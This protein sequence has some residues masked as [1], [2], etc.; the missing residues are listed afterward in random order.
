MNLLKGTAFQITV[1]VEHEQRMITATTKM[2]VISRSFLLA[3]YRAYRT[4]NIQDQ[5]G[6]FAQPLNPVNPLAAEISQSHQVLLTDK[7]SRLEPPHLA[8]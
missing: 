6:R 7:R 8:F 2:A 4:I 3:V 1:L 5:I